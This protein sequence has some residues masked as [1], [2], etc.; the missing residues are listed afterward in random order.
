M[1]TSIVDSI[2]RL[3]NAMDS[4]GLFNVIEK[5]LANFNLGNGFVVFFQNQTTASL[6]VANSRHLDESKVLEYGKQLQGKFPIT[7][8]RLVSTTSDSQ[9]LCGGLVFQNQPFGIFVVPL[10]AG[11]DIVKTQADF[12]SIV[13]TIGIALV[14]MQFFE[15]ANRSSEISKVKID[16]VNH[17]AEL[18]KNLDLDQLLAS[19][20]D[21]SLEIMKAEVGSILLKEKDGTIVSHIELGLRE[22]FLIDLADSDGNPFIEKVLSQKEAVLINDVVNDDR[23]DNCRF[24]E[25]LNSIICLPLVTKKSHL[26]VIVIVN[27]NAHFDQSDFEVLSTIGFLASAAIE[28]AVLR[29][30]EV[31]A[32][33]HREQMKL[34]RRI[35]ENMQAKGIPIVEG[36]E[37]DGWCNPCDETGG[38]YYDFIPFESGKLG[39]VVGDATGHGVSAALTMVAVR[40]SMLSI[41]QLN[42]SLTD[43]FR[44]VGNRIEADGNTDRFMTLF[45]GLLDPET[46]CLSYCS[47]GHDSPLMYRKRTNEII[48]LAATGIPLGLFPDFEYDLEEGIQFERGDILVLATDGVPEAF[49]EAKEAFGVDRFK[50]TLLQSNDLSA[51]EISSRIRD[52]VL[53]HIHPAPRT[54]DITVVVIRAI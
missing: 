37:I 52:V 38:D 44:Y 47:A 29:I 34:A 13:Q 53:D 35:Q 8:V 19:L 40:S 5:T 46:R 9:L 25:Q 33:R 17:V 39:F 4:D 12:E 15:E 1:T 50:Q 54:D 16:A 11:N 21:I 24:S 48:E 51:R 22:E 7:G 6:Q 14:K 32:Q 18:L 41:L 45:F 30:E 36:F 27:A 49:N 42:H 31:E 43:V 26:G 23:I 20:L 28:S 2:N 3:H 10:Q